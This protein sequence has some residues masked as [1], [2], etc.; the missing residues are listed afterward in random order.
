[1]ERE[2]SFDRALELERELAEALA[3]LAEHELV[4]EIRAG[5]GVVAAVQI[6]PALVADDPTLPDRVTSAARE[7]GVLT[8]MLVGGGLQISPPLVITRADLEELE[9]GLRAALDAVVARV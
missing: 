6:D 7:H 5:L 9:I 2:G 4:T 3:P 8:R 1:M